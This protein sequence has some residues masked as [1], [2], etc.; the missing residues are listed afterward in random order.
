MISIAAELVGMHPQTL[1]ITRPKVSSAPRTPGDTA[2]LGDRSRAAAADPA[3]T[4]DLGLNLAGVEHVL[5]LQ[6]ECAAPQQRLERLEHEM[7]DEIQR[8]HKPVQTRARP[9][10]P[11]PIPHQ[12]HRAREHMD[13]NRLTIKSGEAVAGAARC[14]PARE[15]RALSRPPAFRAARP[16]AASDALR[17]RGGIPD[18]L[19]RGGR[20]RLARKPAI[21]GAEPAARVARLR[22]RARQASDEEMRKLEDDYVSIEHLLLGLDVVPRHRCSPRSRRCAAASA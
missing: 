5:R 12:R 21:S 11:I 13:F 16:G 15:P 6:D 1:R 19:A 17:A 14:E 4:T 9:L 20:G 10:P 18:G 8:V 7:R 2:L 3:L 22:P